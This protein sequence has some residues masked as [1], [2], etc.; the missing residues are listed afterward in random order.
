[1]LDLLSTNTAP[2]S[3]YKPKKPE[4]RTQVLPGLSILS[5]PVDIDFSPKGLA[6][7]SYSKLSTLDK[8]PLK[9]Y[10]TYIVK[11]K[12]EEKKESYLTSVGLVA[13]D[14]IEKV[15]A[16]KSVETAFLEAKKK[17]GKDFTEE[18][19]TKDIESLEMS[20]HSFKQRI[21]AFEANYNVR[22]YFQEMEVAVDEN[23][24]PTGFW[25]DNA[26]FRGKIDLII[27]VE[28]AEGIFEVIFIDHKTG[29]P[30]IMGLRNFSKQLDTYKVLFHHGVMKVKSGTSGVHF[31]RDGEIKLGDPTSAAAIETT[32]KNYIEFY[33]ESAIDKVKEIGYF[34]HITNSTCKYCEFATWCKGKDKVATKPFSSLEQ[35]SKVWLLKHEVKR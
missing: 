4:A 26:F 32:L 13:H 27:M 24:E 2:E 11:A 10:L 20:I 5:T 3:G 16:K 17:F 29:A 33:I 31:V 6:P 9:F 30:A 25:S 28:V 23:W 22:R 35:N 34:K 12:V 18:E 14:I 8:C 7:W 1:M 21:E 15:L 19:W